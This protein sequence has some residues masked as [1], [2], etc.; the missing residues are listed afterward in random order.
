[1]RIANNYTLNEYKEKYPF[2]LEKFLLEYEDYDE[3][4]FAAAEIKEFSAGI[5]DILDIK[6][7][8]EFTLKFVHKNVQR[9]L[10][11]NRELDFLESAKKHNLSSFK[12]I[13]FLE[14][15]L[16]YL[17]T[18]KPPTERA[19]AKSLNSLNWQGSTLEFSEFSK[20]LIESGLIGKVT[21]EKEVFEKMK[22]FFNVEDFDKSDKLK[23]VRNRTKTLTPVI[24]VLETALTNWIK[25]KD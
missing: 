8:D 9:E 5:L 3:V 25:R 17:E 6:A 10:D 23:Q 2:L 18:E 14:S 21:N 7:S 24:Q 16:S 13:V 20:A 15:K 4:M 12:I 1:M 11:K 22:D 19:T